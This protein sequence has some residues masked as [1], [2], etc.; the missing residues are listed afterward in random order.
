M[1]ESRTGLD[2]LVDRI[3]IHDATVRYCRGVDRLDADLIRSAY[4]EDAI[5]DHGSFRGQR[6]DVVESLIARLKA[7]YVAHSHMILNQLI[8]LHGAEA[9]V[10]TY[11]MAVHVRD[12]PGERGHRVVY[13]RYL[14]RFEKRDG[15]WRIAT[16]VVT[17]DADRFEPVDGQ[18]VGADLSMAVIGRRDRSDASYNLRLG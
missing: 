18:T 1:C 2:E 5:D 14:D 6:D 10:E 11:Y 16:R 3:A 15:A 13:G 9:D 7:R 12:A 17:F 8:S 4:H